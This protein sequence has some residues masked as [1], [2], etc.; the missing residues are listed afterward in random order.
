MGRGWHLGLNKGSESVIGK[1]D[2]LMA[3]CSSKSL[4]RPPTS[5]DSL[6]VSEI[7]T[8]LSL[9]SQHLRACM[10]AALCWHRKD[11]EH[12]ESQAVPAAVA[13]RNWR[14]SGSAPHM[15]SQSGAQPG[16]ALGSARP[17]NQGR[18]CCCRAC[19]HAPHSA[20]V[21]CQPAPAPSIPGVWTYTKY[22]PC[23]A[24]AGSTLISSAASSTHQ[25]M[26]AVEHGL[27]HSDRP[28]SRMWP[29]GGSSLVAP[30]CTPRPAQWKDRATVCCI[31][32]G[33]TPAAA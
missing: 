23:P 16:M 18:Q 11:A 2:A 20:Q 22:L 4:R 29:P 19:S 27:A 1:S 12:D 7:Q 13:P 26:P 30:F 15:S 5:A 33:C 21:G 32:A 9:T 31:G 24:C 6:V 17:C 8:K 14:P 3:A 28:F 25:D 10:L